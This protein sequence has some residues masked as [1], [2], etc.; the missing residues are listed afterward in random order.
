MR[1]AGSLGRRASSS[2]GRHALTDIP[3]TPLL[4]TILTLLVIF[5]ITAPM[6]PN[7]VRV[8]LPKGSAKES[9]K[10]PEELVIY[11]N[12]E[13]KMFFN[14]QELLMDPLI[15]TLVRSIKTDENKT[16][17]VKA[18]Q[19]VTYGRVLE[20]VDRIKT[21]AGVKYVALATQKRA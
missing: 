13:Q 18:D 1:R 17:F 16:V 14:G 6:A 5:M 20:L 19:A 21:L 15:A 7:S 11:L 10:V 9:G 4:D 8:D 3:L 12:K 2:R